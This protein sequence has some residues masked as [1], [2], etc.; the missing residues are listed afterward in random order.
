M[1]ADDLLRSMG[2]VEERY[3][4]EAEA[5]VLAKSR[6]LWVRWAAA[7]AACFAVVLL[8]GRMLD[9]D[10]MEPVSMDSAEANL[11]SP[12]GALQDVGI[13]MTTA[14]CPAE[15][16]PA[17]EGF[18]AVPN[19]PEFSQETDLREPDQ[20]PSELPELPDVVVRITLWREDGFDAV[21][22]KI[23]STNIFPVGRELSFRFCEDMMIVDGDGNT[24]YSRL[25]KPTREEFPVGSVVQIQFW[26][27]EDGAV[28]AG[29]LWK[30]GAF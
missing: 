9:M 12:G 18:D 27:Q 3:I 26:I 8:A 28:V 5:A 10:S 30:E 23:T 29:M 20:A 7:A 16:S 24:N 6:F 11:E 15:T 21:V 2:Q 1:N 17:A 13:E 22:E 25:E 19:A 4:Q 14:A